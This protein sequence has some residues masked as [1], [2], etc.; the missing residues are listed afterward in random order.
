M[1]TIMAI[2]KVVQLVEFTTRI[3][4]FVSNATIHLSQIP[5]AEIV[6]R[7]QIFMLLMQQELNVFDNH[8]KRQNLL[9]L[10]ENVK[11]AQLLKFTMDLID[12][13]NHALSQTLY[14]VK[15]SQDVKDVKLMKP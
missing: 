7:A 1:K 3:S 6:N 11:N 9:W 15:I 13:V 12:S 4:K 5:L 14:Q 8:V 2:V 10:M